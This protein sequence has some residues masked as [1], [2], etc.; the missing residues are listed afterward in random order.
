MILNKFLQD[1]IWK[2]KSLIPVNALTIPSNF[3]QI[4][5]SFQINSSDIQTNFIKTPNFDNLNF[6]NKMEK[7][8]WC[9]I[10][11]KIIIPRLVNKI[12]VWNSTITGNYKIKFRKNLIVLT[13]I[14]QSSKS[15]F[16]N[17]FAQLE[18][19]I[20]KNNSIRNDCL[21]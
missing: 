5:P 16:S 18:N 9:I 20:N 12:N 11:N 1:Q 4:I 17:I 2:L 14:L 7:I 15:K 13:L 6:N 3:L 8:I 21:I 19:I 10:N